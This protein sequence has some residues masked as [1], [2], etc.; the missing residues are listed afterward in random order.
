MIAI[1]ELQGDGDRS[2]YAGQTVTIRGVVTGVLR[3]GF[4][5][6]SANQGWDKK[7]S[8][9]VFVFGEPAQYKTKSKYYK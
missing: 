9:A 1:R 2:P 4:F 8:N 3:R 7:G 5:L 6:Q